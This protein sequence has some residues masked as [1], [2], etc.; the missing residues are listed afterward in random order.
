MGPVPRVGCG[1]EEW[2]CHGTEEGPPSTVPGSPQRMWAHAGAVP[3]AQGP[4]DPMAFSLRD[5]TTLSP[6]GYTPEPGEP[7]EVRVCG[8]SSG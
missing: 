3:P 4:A 1:R 6:D 7:A 5:L 8:G 2:G